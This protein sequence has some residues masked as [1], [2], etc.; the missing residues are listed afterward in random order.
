[1]RA[2]LTCASWTEPEP[3]ETEP[4]DAVMAGACGIF[5]GVASVLRRPFEQDVGAGEQGDAG[6]EEEAAVEGGEPEPGGAA[7]QSQPRRWCEPGAGQAHH[8]PPMR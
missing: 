7:G 3:A 2:D 8:G 6:E 4:A 5:G 1:M